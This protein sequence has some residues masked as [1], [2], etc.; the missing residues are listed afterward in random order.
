MDL[1]ITDPGPTRDPAHPPSFLCPHSDSELVRRLAQLLLPGLAA[2]CVDSTTGDPFRSPGSVAV[3]LRRDLI[4]LHLLPLSQTFVPDTLSLLSTLPSD[5]P[6]DPDLPDLDSPSDILSYLLDQF[7][8][9]RRTVLG[10][11]STWL[12]SDSR[13]DKIDDFVQD[14]ELTNFWK[15]DRRESV[16]DAVLKNLDYK[17]KH[18]CND[19]FC[20]K[21]DLDDHVRLCPFRPVECTSDGCKVRFCKMRQEKHDAACLYKVLDCEQ[22]CG[23]RVVRREMDRHCVTV[24]GRR[25]ANCPFYQ[26]GCQSALPDVRAGRAFRREPRAAPALR[27]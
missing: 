19:S 13:E 9:S 8:S 1:P 26:V 11:V 18:H 27:A 5:E 15:L 12:L 21:R 6:P 10:R 22:G 4:D 14:L 16:A 2:A 20:N 7:A 23:A 17:N 25:M 24:C 3:D